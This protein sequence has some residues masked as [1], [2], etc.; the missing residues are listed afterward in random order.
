MLGSDGRSL[1]T[2]RSSCLPCRVSWSL[3]G[4]PA[5]SCLLPGRPEFT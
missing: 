1:R 5:V 3:E 4:S 2:E